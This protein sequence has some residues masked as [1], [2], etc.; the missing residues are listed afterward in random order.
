MKK[1]HKIQSQKYNRI[2]KKYLIY[3]RKKFN[4]IRRNKGN[5][6]SKYSADKKRFVRNSKI[7]NSNTRKELL[8]PKN[9]SI[10]NNPKVT[11]KFLNRLS[12]FLKKQSF[13]TVSFENT[14]SITF[15]A[16]IT[17]IALTFK[18]LSPISYE[19]C[20]I[21]RLMSPKIEKELKSWG[22]YHF[23]NRSIDDKSYQTRIIKIEA[24]SLNQTEVIDNLIKF[25]YNKLNPNVEENLDML[26]KEMLFSAK[27]LNDITQNTYDHSAS[28]KGGNDWWVSVIKSSSSNSVRFIAMDVGKGIIST[29]GRNKLL[30]DKKHNSIKSMRKL[31]NTFLG[32]YKSRKSSRGRGLP[33]LR[34]ILQE[35][36]KLSKL[37]V[38]TNNVSADLDTFSFKTLPKSSAYQGTF[39]TW[40][41]NG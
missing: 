8:I 4:D 27:L 15:D 10:I 33:R 28:K 14:E 1:K 6:E 19:I 25:A 7:V 23:T 34:K 38:F 40:I 11:I 22:F 31:K 9:F 37:T 41:Q 16:V 21:K 13:V 12:G 32:K 24:Q 29:L 39:Y 35:P 36:N 20:D 18:Y 26:Y 2:R 5:T 30:I 3:Q 17:L